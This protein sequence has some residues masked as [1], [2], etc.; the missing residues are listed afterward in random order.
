M[1][2]PDVFAATLGLTGP[3]QVVSVSFASNEKRMDITVAYKPQ[4]TL[5]CAH[6]GDANGLCKDGNET[7]FHHN[8]FSYATYLHTHIPLVKC[9]G[10]ATVERPWSRS[11]SK[12]AL[13]N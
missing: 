8:Y 5:P 10:L 11:G 1:D 2:L 9:C 12:F 7:W 13:Q 3:W 6:C 4:E